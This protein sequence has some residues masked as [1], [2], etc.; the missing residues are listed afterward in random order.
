MERTKPRSIR[1]NGGRRSLRGGPWA[2]GAALAVQGGLA[3]GAAPTSLPSDGSVAFVYSKAAAVSAC[4]QRNEVEVRDL[5][6]GVVHLNPFVPV[7]GSAPFSLRVDVT[8]AG[9]NLVRATFALFDK[10]GGSLGLSQVEDPTC[11]GAHLK[12]AASI[13]LLLQPRTALQPAC[14]ACP[15]TGCDPACRTAVRIA[16]REEVSREVRAEELP[17][18]R[19]EA[20]REQEAKRRPVSDWHAVIGAGAVLGFN[21]GA[22]ESPGFWL[23]GEVRSERWVFGAEMR[24]LLPGNA[25]ALANQKSLDIEGMSGILVP[26]V[27]WWW[28]AG[29][30]LVEIGG[31]W[32]AGG[33]VDSKGVLFGLGARARVDVPITAGIEARLFGDVMGHVTGLTASGVDAGEP[34]S[35]DAPRKVSAFVGLGV[36]KVF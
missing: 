27:R 35:V 19:E 23:S 25:F 15:E 21:F 32:L 26:C 31:L 11:D 1:P 22:G 17:K 33:G 6:E 7:G 24:S 4:S 20:R 29:C 30:G 36:A 2:V 18:L 10:D 9:P 34:Y 3:R 28:V 12:L 14:P 5:I 13:A 8:L 16:L